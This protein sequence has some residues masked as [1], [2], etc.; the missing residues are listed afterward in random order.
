MS[1]WRIPVPRAILRAMLHDHP[2]MPMTLLFS[3]IATL[4]VV[5]ATFVPRPAAAQQNFDNVQIETQLVSNN[6]YMLVGAGG[7]IGVSIGEDGTFIV[8]DQFA[9]LTDKIRAAVA[10]ITDKPIRFV[11]NTHWHGDHTGGNEN[12]GNAG[13]LIVAH[14]NVFQRMSTEQFREATNT[15]TPASPKAALPVVTFAEDVTFRLNGDAI[16]GLHVPNA[17]TDGDVLIQFREANVLHLGDTFFAGRFPFID[18]GSGGSVDGIISSA[19][20]ALS[21]ANEETKI[22]PGHGPLSTPKDLRDYRD[23]LM[24]MRSV[25]MQLVAQ[26]KSLEEVQ[27]ARPAADYESWGTGFINTERF[28][29]TLYRDLSRE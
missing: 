19:N 22:I 14:D 27:A 8:D 2:V 12:L 15:T 3:L 4:A 10:A 26:G 9:P 17:H 25:V 11:I 5:L 23:M 6:V 18:L 24:K 16:R 28:V 1:G 29:E 13:A 7:N 20:R 21:I